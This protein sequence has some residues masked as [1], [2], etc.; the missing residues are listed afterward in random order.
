MITYPHTYEM[1]IGEATLTSFDIHAEILADE[2]TA[3][4]WT[5]GKIEADALVDWINGY[6]EPDFKTA[7]V[8]V[9]EGHLYD[10]ILQDLLDN[11]TSD[12]NDAWGHY[13]D[14]AR[15]TARSNAAENKLAAAAV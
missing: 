10:M 9:P 1:R 8:E 2:Y 6:G 13:L 15:D 5:V 12:I 7:M 3:G 11:C 4:E 14:E